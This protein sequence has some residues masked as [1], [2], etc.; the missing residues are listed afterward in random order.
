MNYKATRHILFFLSFALLQSCGFYSFTGSSLDPNIKTLKISNFPNYAPIVYPTLSADFSN[1]IQQRFQQRTNL[2]QITEGTADIEIEG[3]ITDYATQPISVTD[4]VSAAQTRLTIKV[5]VRYV[6]NVQE[7]KSFTKS[8]SS[9]RDFSS[10]SNL[11]SVAPD[12]IPEI[13]SEIIDQIFNA[14]VADW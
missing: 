9:Y 6:N 4:G 14:I 2:T 3:E 12:L 7:T 10:S 11:N 13:N 8:F 5:K 1:D